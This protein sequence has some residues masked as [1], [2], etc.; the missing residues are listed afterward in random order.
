MLCLLPVALAAQ[1]VADSVLIVEVAEG[2]SVEMVWVQGGDFV[3][4]S[5]A[6]RGVKVHYEPTR[7]EHLVHLGDYYIG[8]YEVTQQLWQAVMKDNPSHFR[9]SDSLPVEQVTWDDAQQFVMLLSRMTGYRFRLPTEAE[10]E[11]AARG[12][13]QSTMTPFAGCVRGELDKYCWFCVNSGG[14]THP[15]GELLPNQLGLY[16]MG[17]NVAEWSHRI[18][19]EAPSVGKVVCC[20]VGTTIVPRRPAPSTTV[21]GMYPQERANCMV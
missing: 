12:G 20:E 13:M 6:A 19:R 3:M 17:G 8:R 1:Q 11:F 18:V 5:N 10:W 9:S 7:P 4:G 2:V 21:H 14:H 16:D 15:V